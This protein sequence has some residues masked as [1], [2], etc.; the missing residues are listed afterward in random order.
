VGIKGIAAFA[1]TNG[2]QHPDELELVFVEML[3][4]VV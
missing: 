1:M 4:K 2:R 3:L